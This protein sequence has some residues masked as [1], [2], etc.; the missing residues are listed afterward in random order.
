MWEKLPFAMN[1]KVYMFNYTNPEEVQRGGV[2]IVKEIGPYHFDEWKEKVEVEDDEEDDTITYRKRD[3]F[4]FR[5]DLSGP[6]LTGEEIIIMPNIVMLAV[7]TVV[8]KE[9]PVLLNTVGKAF[10]YLFDTPQDIFMRVKVLDILFRGI[11]VNCAQSD[12][13]PK[14]VCSAL[15]RRAAN[16]LIIEPNKQ[17]KFSLFGKR[18][19]SIDDH[20]VTVKRGIRNIMD[21][22]QVI[23]L[24]GKPE[25]NL[26]RDTCNQFQGTDWTVFPPFLTEKDRLEVYFGDLCRYF[27]PWYQKKTSYNG[28]KTNR[29]VV[30]IGDFAS[31]PNLQ[32]FCETPDTCP[33]KGM[34]ELKKCTGAPMYA[35]LPHYLECDPHF[36]T[37]VK[38]VHP[39][40]NQHGMEIDFEPVSMGDGNHLPSDNLIGLAS[41]PSS[42]KAS[43]VNPEVN[44]PNGVSV[45]GKT[46]NR[47]KTDM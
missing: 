42:A 4:Y 32:C 15:K 39:D 24:D 2:P 28:I 33:P 10:N 18:N 22:G 6:G 34:M 16:N 26:W 27:K 41:S 47:P 7:T 12:F 21:V 25:L 8:A 20:I 19:G 45:I 23:A 3:T 17:F 43:K 11:I 37:K 38:G 46:Q 5:P 35:S 36:V 30:N 31:D 14:A 1:F 13:A 40:V 44:Q 29:Y 9:K